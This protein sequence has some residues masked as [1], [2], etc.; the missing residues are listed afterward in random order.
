MNFIASARMLI[1]NPE[2]SISEIG[3]MIMA[4][5]TMFASPMAMATTQLK[6][7]IAREVFAPVSFERNLEQRSS[8]MNWVVVTDNNGSRHLRMLWTAEGS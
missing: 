5:I 6:H 7:Q 3:G 1:S 8:H 2:A 4:C